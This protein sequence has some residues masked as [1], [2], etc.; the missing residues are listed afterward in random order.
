MGGHLDVDLVHAAQRRGLQGLAGRAVGHEVTAVQHHHLVA[1]AGGVVE[2]VDGDQGADA[3]LAG[4]AAHQLQGLDLVAQVERGGGLVEQQHAG[5]LAE[6]AGDEGALRLPARELGHRLLG[7]VAESHPH[8]RVLDLHAV[9]RPRGEAEVR[10]AAQHHRLAHGEVEGGVPGL[11]HVADDLRQLAATE[12][13]GALALDRDGA[14]PRPVHPGD[15]LDESGLARAVGAQQGAE[16][17]GHHLEGDLV[18][19]RAGAVGEGEALD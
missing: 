14:G 15:R 11:R 3:L 10:G 13:R 1:V 19:D 2:V 5:V 17:A 9:L 8:D 16:R 7:D 6:S 4:D 18:E 12:R